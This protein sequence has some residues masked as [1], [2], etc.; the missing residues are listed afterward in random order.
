MA[1]AATF[2]PTAPDVETVK[3][4]LAGLPWVN[5]GR[6]T[7]GG[8]ERASL[9]VKLSLDPREAWAYGILQNSRWAMFSIQGGKMSLYSGDRTLPKFRKVAVKDAADIAA[10][11]LAWRDKAPAQ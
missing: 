9:F 6:S 11:I 1:T 8:E 5:V 2:V 4:A 10:R 3:E 7:L